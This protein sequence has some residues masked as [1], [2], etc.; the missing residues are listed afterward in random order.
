MYVGPSWTYMGPNQDLCKILKMI[1]T[2][3]IGNKNQSFAS[4]KMSTSLHRCKFF[5]FLPRH[6]LTVQILLWANRNMSGARKHIRQTE[7]CQAKGNMSGEGKH[8]RQTERHQANRKMS[9]KQKDIRGTETCQLN[10][11]MSVKQKH[12]REMETCQF[13][14]NMSYGNT[15]N[16]NRCAAKFFPFHF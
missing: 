11:N 7:T 1:F 12:A 3:F 10:R 15:S 9:G 14:G 4:G 13:N 16:E 2:F 6:L 5:Q 8:V